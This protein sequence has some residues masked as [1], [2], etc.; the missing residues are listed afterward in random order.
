MHKGQNIFVSFLELLNVRHTKDFSNQYFNEHP[1]KY[2]LFGLSKLLSEYGIANA[3]TK[4]SD[5]EK[6]LPEI[7]TPFIAAFGG[8]FAAVH[9]VTPDKVSFLYRGDRHIMPV[10]KF[11]E[12]WSGI[13]LLA[14]PSPTSIE[15][16][17]KAH[18]KTELLQLLIKAL[19]FSAGGFILLATYLKGA[20]YTSIGISLLLLVNL[21]GVFISWQL[22]LKHLHI[23][24][25]Y[26][27]KI[28][29]LFKQSNCNSVLESSA[30]KLFGVIGWSEVGLGYFLTNVLL[31][32]FAPNLIVYIALINIATLPFSFWSV[33]YQ[34][35]KAKQWCPLCLI[36][37]VLLW[38]IFAINCICGFIRIPG[39]GYEEVITLTI[40]GCG[41]AAAILGL[42]V[43]LPGVNTE[44]TAR[45]LRQSI[46]SIKADEDVFSA[47]LKKQPHY[48]TDTKSIIHFGNQ[49]APLQLTILSNP[50]CN[51][52]SKM[53]KRIEELLKKT[54]NNIGVQYF[55]SSFKEGWNTTNKY[56]IAACLADT[57][58]AM[59]I[60]TDWFE[61]GVTLRDDY[62][63]DR[64]F[65]IEAPEVEAEF[66]KHEA[67]R[68]KTQIRATPTILVDGY[69]LPENYKI[70]DLQNFTE[71]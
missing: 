4:I 2:N 36:V 55:L 49:E 27:D 19:L 46:N 41:Y 1:H 45:N 43:L 8:D 61:K 32:L 39:L 44:K 29:S 70:E 58:V 24:S 13:V 37:Q 15:P 60:F 67:W 69:Q 12:A 42:N 21:M 54:N 51:P 47:L 22:M 48:H 18:R 28:C 66:Q 65:D 40:L 53:H 16:D 63:K 17:Y 62:F 64:G 31:L 35:T 34:Y 11:A 56:L 7:Q 5:K 33:W 14:E 71:Y 3:A 10:A 9:D 25:Q 59:H 26:A 68:K 30:A 20:F 50:Y 6:D 52:C 57:S 23:Q 38:S